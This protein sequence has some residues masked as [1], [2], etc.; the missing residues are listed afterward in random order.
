M[1]V[2]PTEIVDCILF[3]FSLELASVFLG[4]SE[5]RICL[6]SLIFQPVFQA[7]MKKFN[8]QNGNQIIFGNRFVS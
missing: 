2:G 8:V 5:A 6:P 7:G 1:R 4:S 3:K